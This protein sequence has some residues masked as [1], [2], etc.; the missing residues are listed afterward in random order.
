MSDYD[1]TITLPLEPRGKGSVRVAG[2]AYKD[3][4]T[5]R[6]MKDAATIFAFA[7]PPTVLAGP[8]QVT[9]ISVKQRTQELRKR[10][11]KTVSPNG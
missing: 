3:A 1:Y 10:Y 8:Y 2:R 4:A 11:K 9:I 6:W 5:D 7:F